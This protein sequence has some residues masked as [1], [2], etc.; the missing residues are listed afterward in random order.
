MSEIYIPSD[1]Y[2]VQPNIVEELNDILAEEDLKYM[3]SRLELF[4]RAVQLTNQK[5]EKKFL[6]KNRGVK[7]EDNKQTELRQCV[8]TSN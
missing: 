2:V 4:I 5:L 7:N 8:G 6:Q 3:K 1:V